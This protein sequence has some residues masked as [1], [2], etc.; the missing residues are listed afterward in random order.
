ML[1]AIRTSAGGY[2]VCLVRQDGGNR[3]E[4]VAIVS[5]NEHVQSEG[6]ISI[7]PTL[8]VEAMELA[9]VSIKDIGGDETT[10]EALGYYRHPVSVRQVAIAPV[11][12]PDDELAYLLLIDAL[13]WRDLDDPW[14]RLLLGQFATLL[15]TYLASPLPGDA[16]QKDRLRIRPRRE[17]IA[18]EIENARTNELPLSLALIYL[19]R[20]EAVAGLGVK[21]LGAAE[22]A[23][24]KALQEALLD[25]RLER[26]GELTYGVF[27]H[28]EVS[29]VEAWALSL[30]EQLAADTDHL[31]G[32]VSIGI[33]LLHDRHTTPDALRADATEALREAFETGACTIIE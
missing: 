32:G 31:A 23:M 7:H 1:Q 4:V 27:H 18:E 19:N 15:G 25:G 5:E 11:R 13:A 2:S 22:R 9:P 6:S 26:F 20:A 12:V 21:A 16:I 28:E 29:D 24:Q 8:L 14:Q 30:Q 10:W 33:A 17:I 3:Y